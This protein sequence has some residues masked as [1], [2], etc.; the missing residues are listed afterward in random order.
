MIELG[1]MFT[2]LKVREQLASYA[3]PGWYNHP[4]GTVA[5]PV[6]LKE[7]LKVLCLPLGHRKR[8]HTEG[9]PSSRK[10]WLSKR[11]E[12]ETLNEKQKHNWMQS[13]PDGHMGHHWDELNK[14][15]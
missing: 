3:D 14:P 12:Q 11:E 9:V 2:I 1:G 5:G 4:P 8:P 10:S 6:N 15:C 13:E 7:E